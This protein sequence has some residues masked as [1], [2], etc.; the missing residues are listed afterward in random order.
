MKLYNYFASE[1]FQGNRVLYATVWRTPVGE[2][3]HIPCE[4]A[5]AYAGRGKWVH[6]PQYSG[7]QN[8]PLKGREKRFRNLRLAREAMMRVA[9]AERRAAR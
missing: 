6:R 1:C 3:P 4:R 5:E 2:S 8:R 9:K 7:L